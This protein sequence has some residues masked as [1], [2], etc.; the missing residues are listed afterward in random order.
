MRAAPLLILLAL[1]ACGQRGALVRLE[2]YDQ[3]S[4]ERLRELKRTEGAAATR[5]LIPPPEAAPL[6]KDNVD[7]GILPRG[8]DPFDLPPSGSGKL[9]GR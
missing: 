2:S 3:V 6:R 4:P 1:A 8:D 5:A 7:D 9:P